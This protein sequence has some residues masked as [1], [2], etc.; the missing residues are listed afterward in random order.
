[1]LEAERRQSCHVLVTL[2]SGQQHATGE[3]L[4][5]AV[6]DPVPPAS[7]AARGRATGVPQ[8]VAQADLRG[9]RPVKPKWTVTCANAR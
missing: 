3:A 2:P 1:M 6:G 5:F 8:R 7:N 4:G 9:S